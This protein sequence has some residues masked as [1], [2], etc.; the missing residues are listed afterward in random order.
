MI[1]RN[2]VGEERAKG[3]IGHHETVLAIRVRDR[4]PLLGV[5]CGEP[6]QFAE[7]VGVA[8]DVRSAVDHEKRDLRK[9]WD[10]TRLARVNDRGGRH[11][12]GTICIDLAGA[13]QPQ[14][15]RAG[16]N[17]GLLGGAGAS[18]RLALRCAGSSRRSTQRPRK[19]TVTTVSRNLAAALIAVAIVASAGA[20]QAGYLRAASPARAST[21]RMAVL[22]AQA[23]PSLGS[24]AALKA[25]LHALRGRPVVIVV[26]QAGAARA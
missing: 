11:T 25:H 20:A 4:N 9:A 8:A 22:Q 12:G 23:R 10:R 5:L 17:G 21:S 19:G 16:G 1:P 26:W 24:A 14:R 18:P 6:K 7:P 3:H 15:C 2:V 13:T